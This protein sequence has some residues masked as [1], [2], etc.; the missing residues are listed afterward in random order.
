MSHRG[1]WP[2]GE[3]FPSLT[4]SI[5]F[6]APCQG[7]ANR[8]QMV[9]LLMGRGLSWSI[10]AS[11]SICTPD[12]SPGN[13]WRPPAEFGGRAWLQTMQGLRAPGPRSKKSPTYQFSF[14][15]L[16]LFYL[17]L[18]SALPAQGNPLNDFQGQKCL[19][20]GFRCGKPGIGHC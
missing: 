10:L 18:S 16:F 12:F 15:R 1:P 3:P 7:T 19:V 20:S 13:V 5:D 14:Q 11:I 2:Q 4:P 8:N 6:R 9:S 17:A